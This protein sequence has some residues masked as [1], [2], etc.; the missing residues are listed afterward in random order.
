[1]GTWTDEEVMQ[2]QLTRIIEGIQEGHLHPT[3]DRIFPAEEVQKAHQFI[4]DAKNIGKVLLK[5]SEKEE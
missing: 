4:H 5:F 3:V 2:R 1:M